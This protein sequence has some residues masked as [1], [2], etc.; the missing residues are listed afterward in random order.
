MLQ[1]PEGVSLSWIIEQATNNNV[2]CLTTIT[3]VVTKLR[4]FDVDLLINKGIPRDN[5]K[6]AMM[7]ARDLLRNPFCSLVKPTV[8]IR[9][10]PDLA[11]ICTF[12][13][14]DLLRDS[15]FTGYRGQASAMC[16]RT[17]SELRQ[18]ATALFSISKEQTGAELS[19]ND[20]YLTRVSRDTKNYKIIG[21]QVFAVPKD[22]E[23]EGLHPD[24]ADG[25]DH[26]RTSRRLR[27]EQLRQQRVDW[28]RQAQ[29]LPRGSQLIPRDEIYDTLEK[30]TSTH[31]K[32]FK[33]VMAR[34]YAVQVQV[35]LTLMPATAVNLPRPE[36]SVA[37]DVIE[38]LRIWDIDVPSNWADPVPPYVPI[39]DENLAYEESTHMGPRRTVNTQRQADPEWRA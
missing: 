13:K 1:V 7:Q 39:D 12:I 3:D 36:R 18:I 20:I 27:A 25:E 28:P 4:F 34:M 8:N 22:I 24:D 11:Y 32:A 23:D 14:R 5:F 16:A 6:F 15:A 10:Y 21:D 9:Q 2:T 19:I 30:S 35:P 33:L 26:L 31:A 38:A 37:P 29:D 17:E